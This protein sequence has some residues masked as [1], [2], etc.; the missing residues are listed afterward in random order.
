MELRTTVAF[1]FSDA[2]LKNQ[3]MAIICLCYSLLLEA[4]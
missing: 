4:Q 1:P 2:A 3:R